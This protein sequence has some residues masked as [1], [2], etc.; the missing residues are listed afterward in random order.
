MVIKGDP[1]IVTTGPPDV[2]TINWVVARPHAPK[3]L[4]I[5]T[6]ILFTL[7]GEKYPDGTVIGGLIDTCELR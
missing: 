5:V 2:F 1:D 6:M 7:P 3:K 4:H